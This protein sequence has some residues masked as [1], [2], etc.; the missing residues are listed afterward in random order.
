[1][2]AAITRTSAA[3]EREPERVVLFGLEQVQKLPLRG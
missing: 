1:L 2:V 3:T